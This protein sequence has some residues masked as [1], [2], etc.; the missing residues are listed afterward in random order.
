MEYLSACDSPYD[1]DRRLARRLD[2]TASRH[3]STCPRFS[4]GNPQA[5]SMRG[6]AMQS[7]ILRAHENSRTTD[8]RGCSSF[9]RDL[10]FLIVRCYDD[11]KRNVNDQIVRFLWQSK[12]EAVSSIHQ[13]FTLEAPHTS[14][15]SQLRARSSVWEPERRAPLR[16]TRNP[17][18]HNNYS[19]DINAAT[20]LEHTTG[21]FRT[22]YFPSLPYHH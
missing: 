19:R 15:P 13:V 5:A 16:S 22:L 14:N 12:F 2:A 1:R 9:T 6:H 20:R 8:P 17:A 21:M 10:K 3:V 18:L 11:Y 7:R 4:I